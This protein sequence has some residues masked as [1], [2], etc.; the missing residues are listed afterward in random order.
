MST[1]STEKHYRRPSLSDAMIPV[2]FLIVAL[3]CAVYLYGGDAIA[4]P[5]QLAMF[6]A[7]LVAIL[8]GL[9]NGHTVPTM[10]KAA[11]DSISSAMGAIFILLSVGALIGSWNMSGTI[12]TMTDWGIQILSPNFFYV[13]AAIICAL[14]ALGIGSSWT[15]MGTIGVALVAISEGLG[16]SMAMTAGAVI[17][18]SY[19]GDKMSPLSE[20]TNLAPAVAGTTLYTHIRAMMATTIPSIVIALGLYT[21]FG[22]TAKPEGA[23]EIDAGLAALEESFHIGVIP[24]LPLLV[25]IVLA[26]R[27]VTPMMAII[28]GA[29]TAS[30][31]SI[32]WQRDVVLAF[33]D[34]PELATPWA[35]LKGTWDAMATGFTADTG[36]PRVDEL[37]TGGGMESI[38]G[39]V[40]LIMV[41]L[42]FG[43]VMNECGFL[44]RLIEPLR[45]RAKG[46]RGIMVSTGTT[47]I[48]INVLAADQYLAIVLTGNLY[49]QEFAEHGIAPQTLSRQIE[50]TATVTSPLIPW[51]SCGAYASGVLGVATVSYFPFAFFN[52]INPIL[53]FIYAVI[54]LQIKKIPP[55]PTAAPSPHEAEFY[56]VSGRHADDVPLED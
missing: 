13:S 53:S 39:T 4:G 50:D 25:V 37:L 41:A 48:G 10:T 26:V 27:K 46:D 29:L 33:V 54:G 22:L 52:L 1:S 18:G 12:A 42:A 11:V 30:L 8:V 47:A 24:M 6:L 14:V 16:L 19:F 51:N 34:D 32:I 3:G 36:F 35:L 56:G 44:R 49:K 15:V 38:L 17:S 5:V 28:A 9:K 55:T 2:L 40:W 23:L 21:F 7:M 31:V 43:G 20:T 45:N